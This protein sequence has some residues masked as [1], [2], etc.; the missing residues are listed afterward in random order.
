MTSKGEEMKAYVLIRTRAGDIQKVVDGLRK[1][2]GVMEA[3]MTFG[4]YDVVAE[5]DTPDVAALGSLTANGI[6]P[7]RGVDQ[8]LTCLTV[9]I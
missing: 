6:Q 2:K 1:L 7:I 4:P 3:H 9:D 5:V 8:T